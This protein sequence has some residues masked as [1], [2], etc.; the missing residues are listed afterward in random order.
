MLVESSM[1]YIYV[2]IDVDSDLHL[3]H[4]NLGIVQRFQASFQDGNGFNAPAI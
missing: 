3:L 2:I 1:L 4:V